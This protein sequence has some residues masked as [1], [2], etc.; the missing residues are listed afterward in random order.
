MAAAPAALAAAA[1]GGGA[2]LM[3][4]EKY[5]LTTSD[6]DDIARAREEGFPYT[7]EQVQKTINACGAAKPYPNWHQRRCHKAAGIY[8][9]RAIHWPPLAITNAGES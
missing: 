2:Q 3:T 4:L 8:I 1:G 6:K 7:V 5:T 9:R